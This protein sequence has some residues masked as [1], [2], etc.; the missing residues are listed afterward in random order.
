MY[1]N[2]RMTKGIYKQN[3]NMA[4]ASE[5]VSLDEAP[6]PCTLVLNSSNGGRKIEISPMGTTYYQPTYDLNSAGQLVLVLTAPMG[7]VKFTGAA[8]DSWAIL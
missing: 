1:Q 8:A 7:Y 4:G 2:I 3:P 5:V 6:L